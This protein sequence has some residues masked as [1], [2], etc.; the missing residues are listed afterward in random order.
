MVTRNGKEEFLL[1]D[2]KTETN[3]TLKN[4]TEVESTIRGRLLNT[5]NQQN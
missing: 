4:I 3:T 1:R 5:G 2:V